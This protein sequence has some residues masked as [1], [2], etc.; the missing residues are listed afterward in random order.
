VASL[1]AADSASG[2]KARCL[3]IADRVHAADG[4][5]Q[6]IPSACASLQEKLRRNPQDWRSW[7]ELGKLWQQINRPQAAVSSLQKTLA[8]NPLGLDAVI[9]LADRQVEPTGQSQCSSTDR[10]KKLDSTGSVYG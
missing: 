1:S 5:R 9:H 6:S 7:L 4:S 8:L 10:V 3:I 2:S